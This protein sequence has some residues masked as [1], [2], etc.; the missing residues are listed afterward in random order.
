MDKYIID[1]TG[2][3]V[4]QLLDKIDNLKEVS[5]IRDG[6]MLASDKQK[7]DELDHCEALSILD[8]DNLLNF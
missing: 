6:I 3:N 7:L 5:R 2:D 8:I 1:R 4:R